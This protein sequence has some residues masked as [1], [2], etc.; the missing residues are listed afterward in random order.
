MIVIEWREGEQEC[1][2]KK[3][4]RYGRGSFI[5]DIKTLETKDQLKCTNR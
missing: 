3:K 1:G 5:L 4:L 2:K